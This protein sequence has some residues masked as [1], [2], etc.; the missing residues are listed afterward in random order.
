MS[1]LLESQELGNRAVSDAKNG[2]TFEEAPI[3]KVPQ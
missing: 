3:R 1:Q 2:W